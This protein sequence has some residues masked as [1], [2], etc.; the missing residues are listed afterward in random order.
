M[1]ENEE[2]WQKTAGSQTV[3]LFFTRRVQRFSFILAPTDLSQYLQ[4]IPAGIVCSAERNNGAYLAVIGSA[5][6]SSLRFANDRFTTITN[7]HFVRLVQLV[8]S[9]YGVLWRRYCSRFMGT[10]YATKRMQHLGKLL[11]SALSRASVQSRDRHGFLHA[12]IRL[13]KSRW[14][15]FKY[16][17][18]FT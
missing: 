7:R 8:S 14:P 17:K 2:R 15:L 18:N 6:T 5:K 3:S 10:T 12:L 9:R 16:C 1:I 4:R 11:V 13:C